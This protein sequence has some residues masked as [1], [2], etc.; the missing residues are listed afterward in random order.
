M[1]ITTFFRYPI[2]SLFVHSWSRFF[3]RVTQT[4]IPEGS[5]PLGVLSELACCSFPLA[6]IT[7]HLSTERHPRKCA[8]LDVLSFPCWPG[9][10]TPASIVAFL[11]VDSVIWSVS[12]GRVVVSTLSQQNHYC[13]TCWKNSSLGTK[14]SKPAE[15]KS[16]RA[17]N[18]H[19]AGGSHN[20]CHSERTLSHFHLL[21]PG[22]VNLCNGRSSTVYCMQTKSTY[23]ILEGIAPAA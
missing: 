6:F 18:K 21:I 4:F 16:A 13:V 11:I 1:F 17:R 7:G 10:V 8:F 22:L 2:H 9:S 14:T 12:S 20:R 3:G 5:G 23:H 15:A 19:F